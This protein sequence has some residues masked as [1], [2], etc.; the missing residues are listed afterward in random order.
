MP[1]ADKPA[2][3][4]IVAGEV[5]GDLLGAALMK[6]IQKRRRNIVFY[7]VGGAAMKKAGLKTLADIRIFP[8]MGLAFVSALPRL[9]KLL[10]KLT[11]WATRQKPVLCITIDN[12]E[13]SARL[14]KRL[15][16]LKVPC[17]Q[18]VAPKVWAWRQGRVKGLRKVFK[19]MLCLFPFEADFFNKHNLPA[20]YV[21]HPVVERLQ[22]FIQRRNPPRKKPVLGIFPGSRRAELTRHWPVFLATFKALRQ[23]MR[24]LT[25]VVVLMDK[26]D[27]AICRQH[28]WD[29]ALKPVLGDARFNAMSKLTAALTKS[30]T[31]NLELA[32]LGVPAVVAYKMSRLTF[33]VVRHLVSVPFI[34][35]PNLVLGK[36]VYSEFI[37]DNA[38][39]DALTASVS[40][41]LRSK[42]AQKATAA[43]L[44]ATQKRLKT[45]SPAPVMAANVLMPYL[46]KQPLQKPTRT[47]Q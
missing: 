15:T 16:A 31:N 23:Q 33:G 42:T 39:V 6:A 44:K 36:A 5:S 43:Q 22:K 47:P 4:L 30:G 25:G 11:D 10:T 17:V 9:F 46:T 45:D 20:T 41:L 38:N 19:H 8:G 34:S 14:A 29:R 7:G 27:L 37:Q 18:Y 2:K 28:G 21:G 12:Q 32:L 1:K 40:Q 26:H 35:P 24:G 3:I 13:F